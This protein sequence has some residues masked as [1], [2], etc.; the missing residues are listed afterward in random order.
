MATIITLNAETKASLLW[1]VENSIDMLNDMALDPM[2]LNATQIREMAQQSDEQ[3]RA[4]ISANGK[5]ADK[6]ITQLLNLELLR[7][8]LRG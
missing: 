3:I 5:E 6:N 7:L 2:W 1:C 8:Q 4:T